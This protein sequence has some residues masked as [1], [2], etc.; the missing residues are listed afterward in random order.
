M[1]EKEFVSKAKKPTEVASDGSD[2]GEEEE[3]RIC[4]QEIDATMRS[5]ANGHCFSIYTDRLSGCSNANGHC[6]DM[7]SGLEPEEAVAA[8]IAEPH[9]RNPTLATQLLPS[10]VLPVLLATRSLPRNDFIGRGKDK[11]FVMQWLRKPSNEHPGTDL[12]RNVSPLS[13]VGH[14][15]MGKTEEF[16]LKMSMKDALRTFDGMPDRNIVDKL[17]ERLKVVTGEDSLSMEAQ[18][19]LTVA[20]IASAVVA[21]RTASI[22]CSDPHQPPHGDKGDFSGCV[23]PTGLDSIDPFDLQPFVARKLYSRGNQDIFL[24]RK[25]EEQQKRLHAIVVNITKLEK[26]SSNSS[27]VQMSS[28]SEIKEERKGIIAKIKNTIAI[29]Q[30]QGGSIERSGVLGR[31]VEEKNLNDNQIADFII[32]LLFAGNK[33]TTKTMLFITYF[34][35]QCP[36]ALELLLIEHEC[37][38]R[39]IHNEILEWDD[40]RAILRAILFNQCVIDETLKLEGIAIW[41]LRKAKENVD[42][43]NF[44]IP[45]GYLIVPFLLVIHLDEGIYSGALPFNPWR[46]LAEENKEKPAFKVFDPGI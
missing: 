23:T 41:L 38:R 1:E 21:A 8:A 6:F 4:L 29:G 18:I 19:S 27:D 30:Q 12:Y 31:L 24:R 13:I 32:N 37:I 42:D 26:I 25:L 36:Q 40:Y 22:I 17:L 39:R 33:I 3:N 11:E 43:K 9:S 16:D 2:N 44:T 28:E 7:Q 35:T 10:V 34:L 14:G 20:G 15:G 46:R 45:Q 5:K